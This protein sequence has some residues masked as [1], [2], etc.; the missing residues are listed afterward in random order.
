MLTFARGSLERSWVCGVQTS[1]GLRGASPLKGETPLLAIGAV[2]AGADRRLIS[3]RPPLRLLRLGRTHTTVRVPT[4]GL[5]NAPPP[6]VG[7]VQLVK[8]PGD[9]EVSM[10]PSLVVEVVEVG[11]VPMD[12][13]VQ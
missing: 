5:D 11:P 7:A 4:P 3:V 6:G 13:P 2:P 12:E 10:I 1:W 9:P 8:P